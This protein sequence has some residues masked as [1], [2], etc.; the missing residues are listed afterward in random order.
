M[1]LFFFDNSSLGV[2]IKG[3]LIKK[4]SVITLGDSN[5]CSNLVFTTGELHNNI[6]QTEVFQIPCQ[7][8]VS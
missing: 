4:K 1:F 8:K 7:G 3:V 5:Y 6:K 2:L